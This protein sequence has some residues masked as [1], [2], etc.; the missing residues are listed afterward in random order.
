EL[1][2]RTAH[3]WGGRDGSV[4]GL[5]AS[6]VGGLVRTG[7]APTPTGAAGSGLADAARRRLERVCRSLDGSRALVV[8]LAE[9]RVPEIVVHVLERRLTAADAMVLERLRQSLDDIGED[10]RGRHS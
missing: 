5:W 9:G 7:F 2:Q 3:A 6:I 1:L 8:D 4:S 10:R